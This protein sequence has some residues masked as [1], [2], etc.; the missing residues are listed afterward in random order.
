VSGGGLRSPRISE[1][2]KSK[3]DLEFRDELRAEREFPAA[4]LISV[5]TGP[6]LLAV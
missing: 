1:S 5:E 6:H 3:K 2:A 4:L